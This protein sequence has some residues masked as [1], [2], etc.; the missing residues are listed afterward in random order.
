[1]KKLATMFK[2]LRPRQW[3]KNLLVGAAPIA[4]GQLNLQTNNLILGI[5][6]FSAASSFGYLINDWKDRQLDILHPRKKFRAFASGELGFKNFNFLLFICFFVIAFVCASLP[7]NFTIAILIYLF[8]TISYSLGIKSIPVLEM[9]WLSCGFL[10]RAIAG[11]II[12]QQSPTGWFL[13]TIGFGALFIVAAKRISELNQRYADLT[14][15]VIQ[16]YNYTFLTLVLTAALTI[17]LI[18]YSLWIFE[19]YPQSIL[20]QFTILPFA[21]TILLYAYSCEKGDAEFPENLIFSNKLTI[22]SM[23]MTIL[24]LLALLYL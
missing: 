4:A 21:L 19:T 13:V 2:V 3:I 18:T 12:I 15:K 17:T 14:R 22:T 9:L 1:V 24:P 5:I 20:A 7:K 23:F 16:K 11:S 6:G 10:T 8:I